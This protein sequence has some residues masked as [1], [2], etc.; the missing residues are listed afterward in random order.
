VAGSRDLQSHLCCKHGNW[1]GT[2]FR[3]CLSVKLDPLNLVQGLRGEIAFTAMRT[4]YHR[5]IFNNQQIFPLA[6]ATGNVTNLCSFL[7]TNITNERR[8]I[9]LIHLN[10]RDTPL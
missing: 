8:I 7:A 1:Y 6:I 2:R 10:L 4:T 5:Y 3:E 9:V